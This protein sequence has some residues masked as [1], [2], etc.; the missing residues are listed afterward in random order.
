M[1][2]IIDRRRYNDPPSLNVAG[3]EGELFALDSDNAAKVYHESLRTDGQQF[4]ERKRK[5]LALCN[6]YQN[7]VGRGGAIAVAFPQFPAYEVDVSL[8]TLVGFSMH[9]FE[10]CPPIANLGFNLATNTFMEDKGVR[11]DDT[12]ALGFIYSIFDVMERLHAARIVLGDVNPGNILY[13][14]TTRRPVI[15]DLDSAQIGTFGCPVTHPHYND[16]LLEQRGRTL[17][18]YLPYDSG[19]DTFALAV[20]CFEFWIGKR[21]F[22]IAH[23]K[24]NSMPL[25]EVEQKR[26]GIS[27]IKC[28]ALGRQYLGNHG[29]SYINC[30]ENKAVESRLA[31]LKAQDRKLYDFFVGVFVEGERENLLLSLEITDPR[32]PGYRFLVE[33]GLKDM[34]DAEVRKRQAADIQARQ[35]YASAGAALPDS[36]LRKVID[37]L[38]PGSAKR[39]PSRKPQP[40]PDPAAFGVFLQHFG[41]KV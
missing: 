31:Q 16:P 3:A 13:N 26:D 10:G 14:P 19:T 27:S 32:H 40:R 30:D 23:S 8:D 21:P 33:S 17:T 18:G 12:T 15:I 38:I 2:L 11:F 41:L 4:E 36:G 25:D 24:A 34:I 28:L 22:H 35:G 5:V 9:W 37:S 7:N 20:V 6:S 29:V 1:Q 39:G